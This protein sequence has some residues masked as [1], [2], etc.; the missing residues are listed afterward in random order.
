MDERFSEG[1]PWVI[2][3][4]CTMMAGVVVVVVVVVEPLVRTNACQ[5]EF[6]C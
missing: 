2:S 1:V 4:V 3:I 6:P 5:L